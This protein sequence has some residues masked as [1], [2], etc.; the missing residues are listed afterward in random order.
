MPIVFNL[1]FSCTGD[2]V[3]GELGDIIANH[4]MYHT[5]MDS[6]DDF[7]M[8]W[9]LRWRLNKKG[10]V[11][12]EITVSDGYFRSPVSITKLPSDTI[13]NLASSICKEIIA[14]N[15]L[16]FCQIIPYVT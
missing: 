13:R 16:K 12:Y 5:L 15:N 9:D 7:S 8:T 14:N 4:M 2:I 1:N 11:S 3:H 10:E 6:F